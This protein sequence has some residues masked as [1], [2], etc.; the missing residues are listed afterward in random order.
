M[1]KAAFIWSPKF[2]GYDL[3]ASHP[4]KP[5]RLNL[6][7]QLLEAYDLLS[8]PEVEVLSPQPA[9]RE[10]LLTVHSPDLVDTVIALEERET[11]PDIY[12]YGLGT[13]DN[14]IFPGIYAAS[15]LYSGAS[16]LAAEKVFSGEAEAAF[17]ISGGLH[18]AH[19][20]RA[21]GFCVFNDPALAIKRLLQLSQGDARVVY[22]DIDAHHGDGVQEAF[23]DNPGVLTISLHETGQ[24]LFP[25]SG[26]VEEIGVGEGKGYA[27]NLPLA[28]D[29]EDEIYLG[30]F[31]EIVPPL[32]EAFR[33]DFLCTQLGVDAHYLDPLTHLSLT[34]T[35]YEKLFVKMRELARGHWIAFGGGGYSSE[36]VPRAWTLAF[37]AM[38]EETLP[39]TAPGIKAPLRDKSGPALSP[40]EIH[41]A[42]EYA[43]HSVEQIKKLIFPYHGL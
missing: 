18:H 5:K 9:S 6:T 7:Y 41:R 16:L 14:P 13:G 28:P 11:P 30:A 42:R 26:F 40:S 20:N 35:A 24:S 10:D 1:T 38:L 15:A 8:R 4:L 3:G 31:E 43:Q 34:T 33:P 17:N 22:L 19:Y 23:Y 25:G 32:V 27:V 2:T 36:V 29:T 37:G 39:D 12:T 21:A